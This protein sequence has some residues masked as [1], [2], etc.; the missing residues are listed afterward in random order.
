MV[1]IFLT[2]HGK[3]I[4]NAARRAQGWCDAPLLPEGVDAA[5]QLGQRL[6]AAGVR[7]DA[8]WA[9]ELG[10][11][12]AT[13][14]LILE[15]MEQLSLPL[16]TENGL[17]ECS[18]GRWEG[19]LEADR[20]AA[21]VVFHG[22]QEGQSAY[23]RG[24]RGLCEAY[25]GTDNTGLAESY[26]TVCDRIHSALLRIGSAAEQAGQQNVLAV[27]SGMISMALLFEVLRVSRADAP[28][29]IPTA[30]CTILEY[31]NGALRVIPPVGRLEF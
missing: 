18:F 13:A 21:F 16:Q 23:S 20:D 5:R 24:L 28:N 9:G 22:M 11:Q 10:R 17:K 29:G 2:R 27:T 25:V 30:S 3:T 31:E 19:E 1:H 14:R 6:K 7:F 4:F 15:A 26:E 12:R 8:A